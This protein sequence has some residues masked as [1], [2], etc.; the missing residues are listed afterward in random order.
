MRPRAIRR[1]C[2][3]SN[4]AVIDRAAPRFRHQAA[5]ARSCG[6][7]PC[8]SGIGHRPDVIP[9]RPTNGPAFD[10]PDVTVVDVTRVVR[11]ADAVPR[12]TTRSGPLCRPRPAPPAVP[13]VQKNRYRPAFASATLQ[14]IRCAASVLA[15]AAGRRDASNVT[16]LRQEAWMPAGSTSSVAEPHPARPLGL[17]PLEQ[18]SVSLVADGLPT[19]ASMADTGVDCARCGGRGGVYVP[20]LLR[21]LSCPECG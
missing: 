9:V 17:P 2:V 13:V 20:T 4:Q 15:E 1:A 6:V 7:G 21:E 5:A 12:S 16:L 18:P 3:G 10:M 14:G 11:R 8:P 19:G